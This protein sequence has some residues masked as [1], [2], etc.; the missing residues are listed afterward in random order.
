[1]ITNEDHKKE[2][3]YNNKMHGEKIN[4]L[5]EHKIIRMNNEATLDQ[6]Y[7]KLVE[8]EKLT[9][10]SSVVHILLIPDLKKDDEHYLDLKKL[11]ELI[12]E[13]EQL[14]VENVFGTEDKI[15]GFSYKHMWV[16]FDSEYN[17]TEKIIEEINKN[18]DPIFRMIYQNQTIASIGYELFMNL[19]TVR[20]STF[21]NHVSKLF[22]T[23]PIL[24]NQILKLSDIDYED[25]KTHI[26]IV[27][28]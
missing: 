7:Q 9:N 1:M 23:P 8:L 22:A 28:T 11:V 4:W 13:K 20:K 2:I 14:I 6:I 5:A 17:D 18:N 27:R 10:D 24:R 21:S 15:S 26:C 19:S 25:I 16:I 12:Y 3:R